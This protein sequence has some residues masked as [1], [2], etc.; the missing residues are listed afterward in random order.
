[1]RIT[2]TLILVYFSVTCFAQEDSPEAPKAKKVAKYDT[3]HGDI[4]LDYYHWLRDKKSPEVIN[5]L[6]AENAYADRMMKQHE[7]LQKKIFEEL[8]GLRNEKSTSAP[9]R[10]DGYLYYSRLEADQNYPQYYRK[11]DTLG[12]QEKLVLDINEL[13][14]TF[15]YF[16][17]SELSVSPDQKT[18]A[19]GVDYT[20]GRKFTLFLKDIE[21]GQAFVDTLFDITGATWSGDSKAIYYT[22]PEEKTL[23][24]YRVY[25][26]IIGTN[27]KSDEL[28]MEEFDKTFALDLSLSSSKEYIFISANQTLSTEVWILDAHNTNAV[29]R[30]V[31][32]R[33]KDLRYSL[34]HYEGDRFWIIHNANGAL[35]YEVSEAPVSDPQMSNW[36]TIVPHRK[37][38]ILNGVFYK[39]KDLLLLQE[40]FE[41]QSRLV[42]LD[43]NTNTRKVLPQSKNIG[44]VGYDGYYKWNESKIR[45]SFNSMI[46][47]SITADYDL[48]NDSITIVRKDTLKIDYQ[49][50]NFVQERLFATAA[51]GA[52][53]PVTLIYKKGVKKNGKN[54]L[55]L[56]SYGSYGAASLP[57]FSAERLTMLNRGFIVAVAHIRGGNDLGTQWY[58]DGKLLKKKNTFTDFITVAEMLIDSQYTNSK[59]LAIQG[60]S[61]GGLLMGAVTNM[62][63]DLF[64]CVVADVPFVDVIN[65]MLDETLPLTTFEYDEWGNPN[66][67]EYYQYMKSYSPYDNVEAKPY[68]NILATGGYND[69]QVAYWEPAKW[70]AKLRELK[71]DS[72]WLLMKINMDAGHGGSSGRYDAFKESAFRLAFVMQAL[73]IKEQYITISGKI[74]DQAGNELPFTNVYV[75]G[76]SIGTTSNEKGE[77]QLNVANP[78]GQVL[79][80]HSLGFKKKELLIE[81]KTRIQNLSISMESEVLQIKT[82]V[83]TANAKDPAYAVMKK[84]IEFRKRNLDNVKTYTADIYLKS[85]VRLN[86]IPKKRPAF[87]PKDQMPDSSDLGLIY[88]SESVARY[89]FSFPDQVKEEMTAS[90]VSG[91]NSGFSW[92]RVEDVLYNFYNNLVEMRYYSDRGFVSPVSENAMFYY[93]YEMEG[94]FIDNGLTINKIK[95]LPR[96]KN[97]PCFRGSVYIVDDTWNIHSL[98]LILTKDAQIQFVDTLHFQQK[99]VSINDSIWMPFTMKMNSKIKVFGF[100]ASDNSIGVFSNYTVNKP[101]PKKFFSREVFSIASEADQKKDPYWEQTRPLVLTEEELKN[102]S[103]NDSLSQI[104]N[105]KTYKDSVDRKSNKITIGKIL[106]SGYNFQNSFNRINW[107]FSSLLSSVQFNTVEGLVLNPS[108][109]YSSSDSLLKFWNYQANIR[110]G[111]ADETLKARAS[112][113][114]MY[115]RYNRAFWQVSAGRFVQQP[116]EGN[117]ITPFINSI[118]TLA[119]QENYMRLFLN[120]FISA[121]WGREL[122][123][124]VYFQ[125]KMQYA[126]RTPMVNNSDF[127][128]NR[129]SSKSYTSNGNFNER[130]DQGFNKTQAFTVEAKF[131]LVPGQTFQSRPNLKIIEKTKYPTFYLNY[132]T[133]IAGVLGSDIAYHHLAVGVGDDRSLGLLGRFFFDVQAGQF[134]GKG[135]MEFID[136]QHF[137]GNQTIIRQSAPDV[138]KFIPGRNRLLAFQALEYYRLS[139]NQA[140]IQAH[141]EH[142]FLSWMVNK[143]PLL[144]KTK[145]YTLAGTNLLL[146]QDQKL[147]TELYF[148]VDNI[149]NFLRIDFVAPYVAGEKLKPMIRLGTKLF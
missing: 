96:R 89:H 4:R 43:L 23:R 104:K 125:G 20:G 128:F 87:I 26:H 105:S 7:L 138:G 6:Y 27:T 32:K 46:E 41:A 75:K 35:N 55:F 47:P 18:L 12:S 11:K 16:N 145:F 122:V 100:E 109:S 29:P 114:R 10:I 121:T 22:V 149:F 115:D 148:G 92:N 34:S 13:A 131:Q 28:I 86:E 127:S 106:F 2:L 98:D 99:Y 139:T 44:T 60:G 97:D 85:N 80:F 56:T 84:A 58:E 81:M 33:K 146:L 120:D 24:S 50:E 134:F 78:V 8:R 111:F 132:K 48:R 59:K 63:P 14:E 117:P 66:K 110:Y 129:N 31:Q 124:G 101:F 95:L 42:L 51:D 82:F 1:M 137:D 79:V 142:N 49:P 9:S 108:F 123:N 5:H 144:R 54:P 36:K 141:A 143:I 39:N 53:V 83:K 130:F 107:N 103:K 62:R 116:N 45:Y 136:F 52:K 71:T 17:I 25:R 61:A 74:Q 30:L 15:R 65:T 135:Q 88:L 118:Y 3:T 102:Y 94:T 70:V 38:V 19:Y 77:F 91:I 147:Y 93:Q 113:G 40:Q 68:P 57:G 112:I 76:T 69:S 72:N 67:A 37:D 64:A 133:A 90:K 119:L 126:D 21:S 73:G 140:Y